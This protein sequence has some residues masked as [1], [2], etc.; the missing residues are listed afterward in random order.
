MEIRAGSLEQWGLGQG[1]ELLSLQLGEP[2][3]G[4]TGLRLELGWSQDIGGAAPAWESDPTPYSTLTPSTQF[5]SRASSRPPATTPT[6]RDLSPRSAVCGC[7]NSPDSPV[8]KDE[9]QDGGSPQ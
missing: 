7:W 8:S 5:A 6:S 1:E 9:D 4:I 3:D 2:G